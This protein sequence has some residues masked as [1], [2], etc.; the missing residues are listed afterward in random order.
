MRDLENRGIRLALLQVFLTAAVLEAGAADAWKEQD[1][2]MLELLDAP[3][4]F[5]KRH[6][7]QGIHIYDT[8]YK[9]PPGGG[10]I[11]V[12]ENPQAARAEQ[13][14]RTII[15]ESSGNSLGKGV[16]THPEISWDGKRLLFCY[17]G[18]PNGSTRIYEI[19]VDG[20][21]LR[22][23]T[24]PSPT[25]KSFKGRGG[26]QHDIAPSYLPDG[27]I[28]FL[29]TR[30]S[31]LVPCN[32]TGVSILHVM[33]ADGSGI[34][35]ISVNSENEF[36]PAVLPDGRIVFGRWEYI[37]K[38]ALTV[39]SLWTINP[40]GTR[41]TAVFANNMVFPE[42]TLDPR[43]VPGSDLISVTLAKHNHT[44]RG[45][46]AM[47]NPLVGKNDPAAIHNFEHPGRPTH[48][49]G[50]SCEPYPLDRDTLVFSGRPKGRKRNVIEM[51]NR[52]GHRFT[53][54]S[55]PDICLHAPMLVKPREVPAAL[56]DLV[57]RTRKS[58][59]FFVQNVY[60]GLAGIERGEAKW[61]RVIE[62]T[63]RVS[64]S[65][66]TRNPF[67]Q[68][69]LVSAALAFAGKIYHG[70]VPINDDGSIYFEAPSG[71][72]LYFQ[73]L[74][75]DKRLIQSMRTFIQAA[76]GTTR[77]CIGCHEEKSNAPGS[78]VPR[79]TRAL[80]GAP[81]RLGPESWGTGYMD[82][83]S[84]I[85][86]IWDRHCVD[87]HGGKDGMAAR[88]DLSGGWTEH[89]NIS[90]E[91]LADR[92]ET[93]LVAHLISGIDCMNGT[94]HWSCRLFPPRTHGSATAPLAKVLMNRH[95]GRVKNMTEKERDLVMAWIDS[96]GLYYGNWDYTAHGYGLACWKG[97]RAKLQA[98]M[99]RA[100][101][102]RCHDK[103]FANDWINLQRPEFSRI[104]RA[105]LAKGGNGYGLAICRNH[106]MNPKRNRL[107]LLRNGYAHAVKPLSAFAREPV[108]PI[109]EGGAPESSFESTDNPHYQ[110]MLEIL[111]D[112]R[113]EALSTPRVDMPGAAPIAGKSRMLTPPPAPAE[114]PPLDA[115]VDGNGVVTL[116]WERSARTIG[117]SSELHRSSQ[118]G[119]TPGGKTLLSATRMFEYI[120]RE[121]PPG[122][123]HYA[124]VLAGKQKRSKPATVAVTVPP[125][126]PPPM[127]AN[128][129]AEPAV[130]GVTITWSG[131]ED[132]SVRYRVYRRA[133]RSGE[134]AKINSAD[135]AGCKYFDSAAE[136]AQPCAYTVRSVSSR[137]LESGRPAPVTAAALPEIRAALFSAPFVETPNANLHGG[138]EATGK[139][140]GKARLAGNALDLRGGGH[141][142][143]AHRPEFDLAGNL[144]IRCRV[145][146]TRD[147]RMPV[148]VS[149]GR[150]RQAGWFLQRIGSGWRWHAGGIDCDGGK[151][152]LGK[153]TELACTYDGRT[154][155]LY[156]D[157]RLVRE[158]SG[159][160][161]RSPWN[162]PL[163]AG[164][165]SG[166]PDPQFQVLGQISN[167]EIYGCALTE[168][169]VSAK[170]NGP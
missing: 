6:S 3:L 40:D 130:G 167:L 20:K 151:P 4:L 143:F 64:K 106:K 67:N 77:S 138:L 164:Q 103:Y 47:I 142:A 97:I 166:G 111:R 161:N 131:C 87:C 56:P 51:I 141:A 10:G 52:E 124:L 24:D 63:S 128:L 25:C 159:S 104:L 105:P 92:R 27:R 139:L 9:W 101:C 91:N 8:F 88:L 70:M 137:G 49:L 15:D 1:A 42:A 19:G 94:A 72:A 168:E 163:L 148:V 76:P 53:L 80:K 109:Q 160:A 157:G 165:Y 38:N 146:I 11:Y 169:E 120:D 112:G 30:P 132:T 22:Q 102:F 69:F 125:P 12:L 5:V 58:G 123:Q 152:A 75:E 117:L 149:C 126:Q 2:A 150:W 90:Y 45:S 144:S 39:Q 65:P 66:G 99:A 107:R 140:H 14:I 127:P 79:I 114:A 129:Q 57:D 162:G 147:A 78:G 89:F 73:V 18:E 153:W 84:M 100:D 74:D 135:L 134:F 71:R 60:D 26:G 81:A 82:Y 43:P 86:P 13:K 118:A 158:V 32:N 34:H 93:Q 110:A 121:A 136:A 119:F 54:L 96:N 36:D 145:R 155:R 115:E 16:Y 108:P 44:P 170:C 50:D 28:V 122:T 61:L 41:E 116:S 68:T 156:Q 33:N 35:P 95:E 133:K 17:K 83:P 23:L 154:A 55:D 29:S 113:R 31:G 7:Y 62:E 85:Q 46:V 37:D 48:D 98:G 21:G 59:A